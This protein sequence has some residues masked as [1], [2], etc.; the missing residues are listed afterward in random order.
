MKSPWSVLCQ[1]ISIDRF[2]NAVSLFN[3]LEEI[4]YTP[5]GPLPD[6]L[7]ALLYIPLNAQVA[8]LWTRDDLDTPEVGR[9]RLRLVSPSGPGPDLK[10][11]GEYE[12][13]LTVAKRHRQVA[14]VATLPWT[15]NGLYYFLVERQA[16]AHWEEVGRLPLE[17]RLENAPSEAAPSE[18]EAAP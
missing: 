9:A 14:T 17:V 3:V 13:D 1:A 11:G 12:V 16:E 8:S 4:T 18:Y 5:Q 7:P 15:E 10:E 2:S 6:P